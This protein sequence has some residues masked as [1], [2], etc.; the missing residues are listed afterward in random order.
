[1][2]DNGKRGEEGP[3][4]GVGVKGKAE[5]EEAVDVQGLAVERRLQNYAARASPG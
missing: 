5:D 2:S 4:M 1:M 3:G